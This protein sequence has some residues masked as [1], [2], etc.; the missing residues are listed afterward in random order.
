MHHGEPEQ[1]K[2]D[3]ERT[4]FLESIGYRVIRYWNSHTF[5][6][7]DAIAQYILSLVRP[8]PPTP[9]LVGGGE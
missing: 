9:P 6:S 3:A 7:E 8:P 4:R 5:E 1:M 2:Y